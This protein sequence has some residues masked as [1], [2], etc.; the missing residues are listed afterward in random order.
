[1]NFC[2]AAQPLL[3]FSVLWGRYIGKGSARYM[4]GRL[5]W[6]A[7]FSTA[8]LTACTAPAADYPAVL[9]VEGT[10]YRST[11]QVLAGEAAPSAIQGTVDSYTEGM[12]ARDGQSNFD[13]SCTASYAMTGG[14][15]AVFLDGV[16]TL[17]T[18]LE[19]EFIP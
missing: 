17:F 4:R 7:V 8:L 13:R 9:Q 14:G 11:E 5:I 10:L 15:L 19:E 18:P 3:P 2:P 12:P 1:M 6:A 16:W